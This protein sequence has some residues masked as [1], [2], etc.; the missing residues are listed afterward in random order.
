LLFDRTVLLVY[1]LPPLVLSA[2]VAATIRTR[3]WYLPGAVLFVAGMAAPIVC[4]DH[5]PHSA[6]GDAI[7]TFVGWCVAGVGVLVVGVSAL[8]HA[9]ARRTTGGR[10]VIGVASVAVVT[11]TIQ[12]ALWGVHDGVRDEVPRAAARVAPAPAPSFD[13]VVQV[14]DR[15][16]A[17]KVES[18]ATFAE[19]EIARGDRLLDARNFDA[20]RAAYDR[21]AIAADTVGRA[22]LVARAARGQAHISA[23]LARVSPRAPRRP[24]RRAS[25]VRASTPRR[26]RS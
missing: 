26:R 15:G 24:R 11:V 22:D 21:G 8:L 13:E 10:G 9:R 18:S 2:S 20:A 3:V 4:R 14:V 19:A 16:A 12:I 6:L 1:V 5:G 23:L 17:D 25:Y 7:I